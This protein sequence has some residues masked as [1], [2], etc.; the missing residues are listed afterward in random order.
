MIENGDW[1]ENVMEKGCVQ[2]ELRFLIVEDQ[3]TDA[4]LCE[5]ELKRAD[6]RFVSHRVDTRPAFE[7]ALDRFAPDLIISD[8]S[9][10][11]SFNGIAAL[12][13]AR[14]KFPEVP[15][16]F[17]SGTIG[18]TRAVEALKRG[19]TDYVLKDRLNRLVPVVTRALAEGAERAERR[20]A[21][22]EFARWSAFLRQAIDLAPVFIFIKDRKGRFVL[23]NQ[24]FADA[25][26]STV[27]QMLGKTAADFKTNQEETKHF[28][29]VDLKVMDTLLEEFT[30]EHVFTDAAGEERWLQTTR[31][32]IV[33]EDGTANLVLGVATDITARKNQEQKIEKLSRIRAF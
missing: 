30:P 25:Y 31:R 26:G 9:L 8:F 13:I 27:D 11:G 3:R 2:S 7:Q 10:S 6:L 4:E 16:I 32:A 19:A 18:E 20:R 28:Q 24:A 15:F 12:D 5:R 17:V 21:E 22:E 29:Q 1:S 23:V 33:S 14:R